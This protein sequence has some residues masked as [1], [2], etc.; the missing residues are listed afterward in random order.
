MT[1]VA[2]AVVV[3]LAALVL[4]NAQCL[5]A[6]AVQPCHSETH[7]AGTQGD[8]PSPCH[9]KPGNESKDKYSGCSHESL[10]G[11]AAKKVSSDQS[12]LL[13]TA[14]FVRLDFL[15]FSDSREHAAIEPLLLPTVTIA[16]TTVLRI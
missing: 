6:C 14:A 7:S 16:S 13:F 3:V 8:Q 15:S 1:R 9:Q 2:K 12:P 10:T 11:D 4:V 5:A